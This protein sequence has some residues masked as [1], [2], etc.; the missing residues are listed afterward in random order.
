MSMASGFLERF[1][2]GGTTGVR[3]MSVRYSAVLRSRTISEQAVIK[4][5]LIDYFKIKDDDPQK[6]MDLAVR[7]L[8]RKILTTLISEESS[9]LSIKVTTYDKILSR[10]IA[11]FYLEAL[12]S[13]TMNNA[14]NVG[15]Q[16]RELLEERITQIT[17]EMLTLIDEIRIYQVEHN[18]VEIEAQ[19]KAAI[20]GYSLIL[21]EFFEVD[22]QLR[23]SEIDLPGSQKTK[24]LRDRRGV[25]VDALRRLERDN[26]DTP[27]FLALRNI[28]DKF[29]TIQEKIFGLEIYRKL[30]E[31]LY[32]QFELARIEE[33]DNLDKIEIIDMPN[34]PGSRA[35]PKR[36]MICVATFMVSV[37]FS[38]AIVVLHGYTSEDDKAKIKNIWKTLFK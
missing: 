21:N 1:G 22:L 16:K 2:L 10:D 24:D 4:F 23:L 27:F 25:I 5:N 38:S 35:H 30:L 20:E 32:P 9:F 7:A 3:T 28:N 13:Y 26:T 12:I 31:T 34:I 18:V 8:D 36:A 14:N 37:L 33:I 15:R 6:A 17:S 11:M 29:L 19:A